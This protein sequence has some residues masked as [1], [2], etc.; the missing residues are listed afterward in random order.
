MSDAPDEFVR[1]ER[2]SAAAGADAMFDA[3][4]ESLARRHRWH[5]LFDARLMQARVAL[6]LSPA[7]Q[8]GD[9]PAAI[10]DDLDARSLAACREAGWPLL[11]EGHVA[12]AWMYLRAA[13]PAGEVATRL[14]NLVAAAPPAGDD[15]QA[16]RLCD[17][18]LAV[19]LWEGVDP[20]LGISLLL[21]TQ[22][23]CNAVTAYEQAVSRLPAVRQQPAA[24]VLVAHLHGEVARGLAGE[25]AAGSARG[26]TPIVDRL[27]AADAAG[28]DAGLYCDVSHLQ[29]VL[30]IARVCSDEPTLRRAW[31]LACYACRLP[32]E[33]VYPGEPPFED[34]GRA[35]RLFFGAQLGHDV[36]EAVAHFRRAA[37]LAD[38]GDTL[39]ADVLMLLL[40]R[41]GRLPE[42]LAAALAQPRDATMPGI[43]HTTGMLPSL[44]ELA[45]AAGDWKS[46]HRACLDR[47]D[48]ITFAAA[49]AA[50]HHQKVGNQCRQPPAQGPQPRDW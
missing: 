7:G 23:T 43:M 30:R 12:A 34:V 24:S 47:G 46:L 44:V 2:I 42:A 5:A 19:A 9:L 31:E 14:A 49:L 50:E 29:S 39:P 17:E 35:S 25:T 10:R 1:L 36:N 15:E 40:W 37:A 8:L 28:T 41:L 22:G 18:I 4:A 32:A 16:A 38:S 21:Q 20:A 48:E 11:D 13:A 6:G 26:D 27:A 3:L 45:A 33:I